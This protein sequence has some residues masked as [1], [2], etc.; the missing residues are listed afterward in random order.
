MKSHYHTFLYLKTYKVILCK[1]W[2]QAKQAHT[3]THSPIHLSHTLNQPITCTIQLFCNW[4]EMGATC[5]STSAQQSSCCA[6][7]AYSISAILLMKFNY[8]K[9]TSWGSSA[10]I[11]LCYQTSK[12]AE[13]KTAPVFLSNVNKT[14]SLWFPLYLPIIQ[15]LPIF[16]EPPNF[17]KNMEE[18]RR[19]E[20]NILPWS[21]AESLLTD[22][23]CSERHW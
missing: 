5:I 6:F 23:T 1:Y 15:Y 13:R 3:R 11:S 21:L 7:A 14:L 22:A 4:A 20:K 9:R 16:S 17:L 19:E 8:K 18:K 10:V 2:H 12:M